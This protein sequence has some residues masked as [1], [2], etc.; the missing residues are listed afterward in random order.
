MTNKKKPQKSKN[1]TPPDNSNT[2]GIAWDALKEPSDGCQCGCPCHTWGQPRIY[3]P[4]ERKPDIEPPHPWD[5][6]TRNGVDQKGKETGQSKSRASVS[7]KK[8]NKEADEG[9]Q[10][11][12]HES[13]LLGGESWN[14]PLPGAV[15][16]KLCHDRGWETPG[17]ST[18]SC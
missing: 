2:V 8:Q 3:Q 1:A 6:I 16:A 14:G 18:I 4:W 17:Y 12:V 10:P 13:A 9:K 15:L 5:V 11:A 7:K